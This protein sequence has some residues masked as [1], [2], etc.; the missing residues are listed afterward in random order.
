MN[1]NHLNRFLFQLQ[2]HTV[3]QDKLPVRW[4]KSQYQH[5]KGR[6]EKGQAHTGRMNSGRVKTK[7]NRKWLGYI[8]FFCWAAQKHK[9]RRNLSH[10]NTTGLFWSCD[11][12]TLRPVLDCGNWG[13]VCQTSNILHMY[14]WIL[15]HTSL[16]ISMSLPYMTKKCH[17]AHELVERYIIYIY[18]FCNNNVKGKD[19]DCAAG[20]KSKWTIVYLCEKTCPVVIL[21]FR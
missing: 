12:V 20:T 13:S 1:N 3:Q 5:K 18:I 9:H 21:D 19:L 7:C 4:S 8:R 14:T 17:P 11:V 6:C 16:L 15:A 2:S 10:N